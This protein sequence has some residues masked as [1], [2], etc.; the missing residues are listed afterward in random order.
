M[1]AKVLK[2]RKIVVPVLLCAFIV[3]LTSCA[4]QKQTALVSDPDDH[5]G[6]AIPWNKQEAW[7]KGSQFQAMT[8]R[9]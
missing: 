6:S 4:A 2:F 1:L 9:R 7:E 3:A 5:G 8:D